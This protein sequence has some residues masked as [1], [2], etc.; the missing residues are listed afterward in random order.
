MSYPDWVEQFRTK[1]TAINHVNGRYYLYKVHSERIKGTNKIRKVNDEY[2]GR[3]TEDGLVPPKDKVIVVKHYG[4]IIILNNICNHVIEA[5]KRNN[6]D[7][8]TS[9]LIIVHSYLNHFYQAANKDFY[10]LSYISILYPSIRFDVDLN[11]EIKFEIDRTAKMFGSKINSHKISNTELNIIDSIY[12]VL[13]GKK[14]SL[15]KLTKA[16]ELI[17]KKHNFILE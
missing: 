14:W 11:E 13:I 15:S 5:I 10:E 16:Q 9:E 12:K 17:V 8:T 6:K 2:L 1:G 4:N 3:I 7:F